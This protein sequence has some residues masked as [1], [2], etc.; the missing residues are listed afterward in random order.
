MGS[1]MGSSLIYIGLRMSRINLT[2]INLLNIKLYLD[3]LSKD[4]HK[5]ENQ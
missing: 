1:L 2:L 3:N 4:Y 5:K